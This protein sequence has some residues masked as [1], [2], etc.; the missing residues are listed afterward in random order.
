[1]RKLFVFLL[2]LV[3]VNTVF[4][5]R[6][7]VN[8]NLINDQGIGK[9]IGT[10]TA[11]DTKYGL[12]LTPELHGLPQGSHGF[13]VH[14]NAVCE[15]AMKDG[16][17]TAGLAAGDHYDPDKA[18]QHEGPYRNGHL[19]DLPALAVDKSG[20][21]TIPLLA[22]RLKVEDLYGHSFIIHAGSDNYS[23]SPQKLGGGG[24]RIA[25]GVIQ[26]NSN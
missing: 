22:P 25:C 1:M 11:E 21:A 3:A 26:K 20:N 6:L 13:H 9:A 12:M 2:S 18:A 16:K 10:I 19:G 24:A 4:A 17:L 14:Q 15:P 7:T 23:D 8:M 5:A